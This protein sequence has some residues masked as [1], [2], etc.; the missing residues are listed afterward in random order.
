MLV[1]KKWPLYA[2]TTK[3]ENEEVQEVPKVRNLKSN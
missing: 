2:L 1:G 3:R